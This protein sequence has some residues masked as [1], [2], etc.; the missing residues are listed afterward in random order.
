MRVFSMSLYSRLWCSWTRRAWLTRVTHGAAQ[1]VV[2]RSVISK[3][4][5]SHVPLHPPVVGITSHSARTAAQSAPVDPNPLYA[6]AER[7][8]EAAQRAGASYADARL[9][10][11]VQH[12][13]RM[14]AG[15][16]FVMDDELRGVGVRVLADGCW[17]FAASPVWDADEVVRLAADAVSQAKA[18]ATTSSSPV[19]LWKNPTVKGAWV[20]PIR[21][22]PFT[23]PVEEKFDCIE[24]W[25]ACAANAGI[26]YANNGQWS[27]ISS[28]RQERI[29]VTSEGTRVAQTRYETGSVMVL[30]LGPVPVLVRNVAWAGKGWELFHDANFLNEFPQRLDEARRIAKVPST[31]LQ[32]GRYPIVCDG[33]TMA[34]ILDATLGV[35]TQLDRALGYE[36][37]ASGTSYLNDPLAML[38][39]FQVASPLVTVTANRSALAQLATVQWD[40][41]G[42]APVDTSL[43]SGGVLQDFQTTR[44]QAAWLAPYYTKMGRLI[45]SKGYAAAEDALSIPI[46]QSP[47]LVLAPGPTGAGIE[48]MVST[49]KDGV[50][51]E[52]GRVTCDFQAKTGL[53]QGGLLREI[54]N[55]R[56]GK[57]LNTGGIYFNTVDLWKNI[58]TLGDVSTYDTEAISQYERMGEIRDEK[59]EP[60]QRSSHTVLAPAAVID[61]Q[62]LIDPWR[63]A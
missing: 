38:G 49:I 5:S 47:N 45:R 40:D 11:L 37:N 25:K 4:A 23:V 18:N 10:R 61:R 26:P 15:N 28:V 63:K 20:T 6:L 29:L 44:E 8:V 51:V 1:S 43:V 53:L 30:G 27:W 42:V 35:A 56:L 60:E 3:E 31:A 12:T 22:D 14:G 19:E 62:T 21:I 7:A 36:A 55:G 58:K 59:G 50:F 2:L 9:T 48:G 13:Y 32:V 57:F 46:Q 39:Q 24:Y 41:E 52:R 33:V 17:G 16:K 54:K 34:R